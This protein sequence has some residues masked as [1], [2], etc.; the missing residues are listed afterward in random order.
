MQ[1]ETQQEEKLTL[2]SLKKELDAFKTEVLSRLP[3]QPLPPVH[4]FAHAV[5]PSDVAIPET[6]AEMKIVFHFAD[7]FTPARE[8][9]EETHGGK[10]RIIAN[11]FHQNNT[12]KIKRREDF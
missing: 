12:D 9:S 3:P 2:K 7:R 5:N 1:D 8:F 11:E 6:E 10:W 4:G